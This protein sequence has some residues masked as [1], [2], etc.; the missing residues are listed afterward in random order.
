M[1]LHK[2]RGYALVSHHL[3]GKKIACYVGKRLKLMLDNQSE[4]KFTMSQYLLCTIIY[5]SA[6]IEEA[7]HGPK[8]LVWLFGPSCS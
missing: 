6:V 2:L 8:T 3:T 4:I 7:T 5:W 1:S